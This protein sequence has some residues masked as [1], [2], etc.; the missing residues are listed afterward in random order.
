MQAGRGV[1]VVVNGPRMVR[2]CCAGTDPIWS[3]VGSPGL[4]SIAL[5]ERLRIQEDGWSMGRD[6]CA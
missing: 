2:D 1:K 3:R 5:G 4:G 6:T